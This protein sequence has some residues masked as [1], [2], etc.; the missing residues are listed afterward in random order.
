[1]HSVTTFS[2]AG[3]TKDT[4]TKLDAAVFGQTA[5]DQLVAQAYRTYMA[6]GRE[7]SAVTLKRGQVAG[8]GK[9]PWKQKGT[10]RARVGSIRVP[11]W[12][13]GGVV[14]GPTGIQNFKLALPL[15]MKR[16]AIRHALS[17]R[18]TDGSIKVIENFDS[19]DGK[20]KPVVQLL[21]K[22]G[23]EGDIVMIVPSKTDLILRAT[24]NVRGLQV[25]SA[26]YLNVYT[27][28]NADHLVFTSAALT[29]VSR[30]LGDK[31]EQG[32]S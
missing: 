13:G 6:N 23:L 8:G 18:A 14:F 10:G 1:M 9:K 16:T 29:E 5:S 25:V 4:K 15:R 24:R 27:I 28:M 7:A 30:W 3:T 12:R 31:K 19:T 21:G 26:N 22:I 2:A 11:N 20:V 32:V 17:L